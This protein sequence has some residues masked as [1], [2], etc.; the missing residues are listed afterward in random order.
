M[1]KPSWH[2]VRYM[3]MAPE[4]ERLIH[5]GSYTMQKVYENK[6]LEHALLVAALTALTWGATAAQAA[7]ESKAPEVFKKLDADGDGF[8]TAREAVT[9]MIAT[10]VFIAADRDNNGRLDTE[11][12]VAAG[13]DNAGAKPGNP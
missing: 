3:N 10:E 5:Y 11:E 13:L 12:Y 6:I 7:V 4:R 8:L 1:A 9:G 2:D